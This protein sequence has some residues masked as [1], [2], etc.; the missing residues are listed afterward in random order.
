MLRTL[1]PSARR[2]L[3]LIAGLA[4]LAIFGGGVPGQDGAAPKADRNGDALPEGALARLGTLRWRHGDAVTFVAFVQDG[5]AILT[6][7]L[8]NTLRLWDAA[9]GKEIRRFDMPA[10]TTPAMKGMV[11]RQR[12]WAGAAR[13]SLVALSRDGKTLAIP[14]GD[15]IQLV[16]VDSGKEIRKIKL[17]LTGASAIAFSPDGKTLAAKSGDS[18]VYLFG[19][20]DGKEIRQIKG[21]QVKAGGVRVLIG[22]GFGAIVPL[23]FSADGKTIATTESEFD[24]ANMKVIA[25][26]RISS[27]ENGD[28]VRKIDAAPNGAGTVVFAADGK[29]LAFATLNSVH[30][31]EAETSDVR[32]P[33]RAEQHAVRIAKHGR[34][35]SGVA[36]DAGVGGL[37]IFIRHAGRHECREPAAVIG[38]DDDDR[39]I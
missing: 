11:I 18:A 26:V 19:T 33:C 29:T 7:G 24:Q 23:A 28:E 38:I 10:V 1:F 30:L 12:G 16:E 39:N 27:V 13:G 32:E 31:H 36:S 22:G 20:D 37:L 9:S 5:K 21:M 6:G 8:D 34:V 17:P 3:G 15:S 14:A 35:E 4:A 25:V 2:N